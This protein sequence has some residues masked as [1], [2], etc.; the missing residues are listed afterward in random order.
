[1]R[2]FPLPRVPYRERMEQLIDIG[3]GPMTAMLLAEREHKGAQTTTEHAIMQRL[4]T[5]HYGG[6]VPRSLPTEGGE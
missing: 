5:P 3:L 6:T 2:A 1:M 4:D